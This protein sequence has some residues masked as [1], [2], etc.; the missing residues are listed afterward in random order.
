MSLHR[1]LRLNMWLSDLLFWAHDAGI[2]R[3]EQVQDGVQEAQIELQIHLLNQHLEVP[4]ADKISDI[5]VRKQNWEESKMEARMDC[6]GQDQHQNWS[7]TPAYVRQEKSINTT[8]VQHSASQK[9]RVT[10][11]MREM[12]ECPAVLVTMLISV[13]GLGSVEMFK[14]D[15]IKVWYITN[16]RNIMLN[17]TG[18]VQTCIHGDRFW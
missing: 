9:E 8:K 1:K 7:L 17:S 16:W 14:K 3:C 15:H 2:L 11:L 6:K 13:S 5:S 4:E 10:Y 18:H 12:S